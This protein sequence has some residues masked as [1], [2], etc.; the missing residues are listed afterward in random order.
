[1]TPYNPTYQ[2][3]TPIY[4]SFSFISLASALADIEYQMD[5]KSISICIKDLLN[6]DNGISKKKKYTN[7]I[8]TDSVWNKVEPHPHFTPQKWIPKGKF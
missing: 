7:E 5:N 1:M 3:P 8:I 6:I 2:L 4:N